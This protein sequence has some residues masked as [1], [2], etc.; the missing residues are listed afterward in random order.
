MS[1]QDSVDRDS[2]LVTAVGMPMLL[3]MHALPCKLLK[4]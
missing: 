1:G 3:G 4:D 2:L